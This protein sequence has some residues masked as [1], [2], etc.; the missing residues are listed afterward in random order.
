[1]DGSR[2][3]PDRVNAL[4]EE[5]INRFRLGERP[6]VTEY[7]KKYPELAD[8]IAGGGEILFSKANTKVAETAGVDANGNFT[9]Q[10]VY[11]G[12]AAWTDITAVA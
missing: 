3:Q 12:F 6:S 10:Q 11:S 9:N 5:F 4:A 1:M 2:S 7:T 8:N